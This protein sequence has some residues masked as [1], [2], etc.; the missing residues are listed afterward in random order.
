M[1]KI[2]KHKIGKDVERRGKRKQRE[3]FS[4]IY[5]KPKTVNFKTADQVNMIKNFKCPKLHQNWPF[6]RS[7]NA[8]SVYPVHCS[9]ADFRDDEKWHHLSRKNIGKLAGINP[10]G[11]DEGHQ[12]LEE[13]TLTGIMERGSEY[14]IPLLC[15]QKRQKAKARIWYYRPGFIRNGVDGFDPKQCSGKYFVFHTCIVKSG[16]WAQ[17]SR[18]A[19]ALYMAM[20]SEAY[21]DQ[22]AYGE[23]EGVFIADQS[24]DVHAYWSRLSK[25]QKAK[26][27]NRK[28]DVCNTTLKELFELARISYNR[29]R[30]LTNELEEKGLIERVSQHK[31]LFK[32]WLKPRK[33]CQK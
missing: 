26:F 7:K 31:S 14:T 9:Y 33:L 30:E 27:T 2:D 1:K 13:L 20:R 12:E 22:Q 5:D 17:L 6:G 11:V 32:V 25:Q 23:I 8:L 28:W 29:T 24:R 4:R 19:K 10:K 3:V 15:R 18:K 16:V 21:F